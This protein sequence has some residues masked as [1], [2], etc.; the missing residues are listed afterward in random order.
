MGKILNPD[1][2]AKQIASWNPEPWNPINQIEAAAEQNMST[3]NNITPSAEEISTEQNNQWQEWWD[4]NWQQ[5]NTQENNNQ[6]TNNGTDSLNTPDIIWDFSEQQAQI[7]EWTNLEITQPEPIEVMWWENNKWIKPFNYL[8][9]LKETNFDPLHTS[10]NY[11]E[12]K[13]LIDSMKNLTYTGEVD[14]SEDKWF[15][16]IL[17]EKISDLWEEALDKIEDFWVS[18]SSFLFWKDYAQTGDAW[19]YFSK[20]KESSEKNVDYNFW[21]IWNV[22]K[23]WDRFFRW[24][25]NEAKSYLPWQDEYWF[26]AGTVWWTKVWE[27]SWKIETTQEK[28]E[29]INKKLKDEYWLDVDSAMYFD[30]ELNDTIY[31][32]YQKQIKPIDAEQKTVWQQMDN[33]FKI[34]YKQT[35][36]T[37]TGKEQYEVDIHTQETKQQAIEMF[38]DKIDKALQAQWLQPFDQQSSEVQAYLLGNTINMYTQALV[39]KYK[40]LWKKKVKMLEDLKKDTFEEMKKKYKVNIDYDKY[41]EF[42]NELKDLKIDW[43]TYEQLGDD[44]KEYT[45]IVQKLTKPFDEWS[46]IKQ[47]EMENKVNDFFDLKNV[48]ILWENETLLKLAAKN[49]KASEIG[50]ITKWIYKLRNNLSGDTN[51]LFEQEDEIDRL[52]KIP[53][54]KVAIDKDPELE[55]EVNQAKANITYMKDLYKD[56]YKTLVKY[57]IERKDWETLNEY[58]KRTQWQSLSEYLSKFRWSNLPTNISSP[59]SIFE[60]LNWDT[61][62]TIDKLKAIWTDNIFL[63][64]YYRWTWL[65]WKYIDPLLQSVT[66]IPAYYASRVTLNN[67]LI[68]NWISDEYYD[69]LK[70]DLLW[71]VKWLD[72]ITGW[73]NEW[74][75][76]FYSMED[77]ISTLLWTPEEFIIAKWG[78][79]LWSKILS[80]TGVMKKLTNIASKI[81]NNK[82]LTMS[83]KWLRWLATAS[84]WAERWIKVPTNINMAKFSDF[85]DGTRY[86]LQTKW[87]FN[88][89]FVENPWLVAKVLHNMSTV[90]PVATTIMLDEIWTSLLVN[91]LTNEQWMW[92]T[93]VDFFLD[94]VF[95]MW[96]TIF[97]WIKSW[98][99]W[100]IKNMILN[101]KILEE[102]PA[103]AD[104]IKKEL[105][106]PKDA[107]LW[108]YINIL[109][110]VV[111]KNTNM[112]F[113]DF[114]QKTNTR[115][116]IWQKYVENL[117][118]SWVDEY[119]KNYIEVTNK[120][121][122]QLKENWINIK[123]LE[124][125][126]KNKDKIPEDLYNEYK[127]NK[128][129]YNNSLW[130]ATSNTITDI[131]KKLP[132]F[133]FKNINRQLEENSNK[134][135]SKWLNKSDVPTVK[136]RDIIRK[137][138][139]N[140]YITYDWQEL[141]WENMVEKYLNNEVGGRLN[142]IVNQI[143]VGTSKDEAV[144]VLHDWIK[145][146]FGIEI[147]KEKIRKL[148]PRSVKNLNQDTLIEKLWEAKQRLTW[149]ISD[150]HLAKAEE[151][152]L[153]KW[154]RA[155]ISEWDEYDIYKDRMYDIIHNDY[156]EEMLEKSEEFRKK[157]YS[158]KKEYNNDINKVIEESCKS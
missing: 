150:Y 12:N 81:K 89:K 3:Q 98:V 116:R 67:W 156:I 106:L 107:D 101:W 33:L 153:P 97:N 64:W 56:L 69:F 47:K 76:T 31:K 23:Y 144:N 96:R 110:E 127:N 149:L 45:N 10:K 48:W 90:S 94:S 57:N 17:W 103:V 77:E 9:Y 21:F 157:Y 40:R 5:T 52:S 128:N 73:T 120:I 14:T 6:E 35:K 30:N 99:R 39:E 131:K 86:F 24:L 124:D 71:A 78:P 118:K 141:V 145:N 143:T 38:K 115:Q 68:R 130:V 148:L 95:G 132:E 66:W 13:G 32:Q 151:D 140:K 25:A 19:E 138:W 129:L 121:L 88:K 117:I 146:E 41:E 37:Q 58:M 29:Q 8:D 42:K 135:I 158:L 11:E 1:E 26:L 75:D 63:K 7:W 154:I 119:E 83:E 114:I 126:E 16:W 147:S 80:K 60:V 139:N 43:E 142:N 104:L 49:N 133:K 51:M 155:S 134:L 102:H 36:N 2:V 85:L 93:P 105:W 108:Q 122:K 15:F 91:W 70:N 65:M 125:I 123:W 61:Q 22:M 84:K 152:W 109:K 54:I 28:Q 34:F 27:Y 79:M 72:N 44:I 87:V 20:L 82:K 74:I 55:K 18:T 92:I 113:E 59:V 50:K 111:E 137:Y 53:S 46:K 4:E 62:N 112:K 136:K 100:T